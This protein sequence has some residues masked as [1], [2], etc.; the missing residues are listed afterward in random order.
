MYNDDDYQDSNDDQY[1]ND[2]LRNTIVQSRQRRVGDTKMMA[3]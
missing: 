3:R 1:N 2:D